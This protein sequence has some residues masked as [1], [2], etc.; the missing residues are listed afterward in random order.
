MS[1]SV[2]YN[3]SDLNLITIY[4][5][6][7]YVKLAYV[8]NSVKLQRQVLQQKRKRKKNWTAKSYKKHIKLLWVSVKYNMY[9]N[10]SS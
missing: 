5:N 9:N 2:R 1:K 3:K 10:K 7:F 4:S 8:K 6:T